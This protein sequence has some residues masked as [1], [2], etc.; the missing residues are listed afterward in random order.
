MLGRALNSIRS[1]VIFHLRNDLYCVIR[2]ANFAYWLATVMFNRVFLCRDF[3][4][5]HLVL[6]MRPVMEAC[7]LASISNGQRLRTTIETVELCWTR[8]SP[9]IISVTFIVPSLSG[10]EKE[11]TNGLLG[12]IGKTMQLI[13][14][15]KTRKLACFGQTV[16]KRDGLKKRHHANCFVWQLST[17]KT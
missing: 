7:L 17:K 8:L 15:V 2:S 11:P 1:P 9:R 10:I 5:P 3:S 16:S 4:Q 6:C 14:L 13:E 12:K